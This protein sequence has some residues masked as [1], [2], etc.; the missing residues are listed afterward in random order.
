MEIAGL[1][2]LFA[3]AAATTAWATGR[4]VAALDGVDS[5][6]VAAEWFLEN[7]S[8]P[9]GVAVEWFSPRFASRPA[10]LRVYAP[11]FALTE[12]TLAFYCGGGFS[13]VI[14]NS[15]NRNVYFGPGTEHLQRERDWYARLERNADLLREI[16]GA[17]LELHVPTVW[18]YRLRCPIDGERGP[19]REQL[20]REARRS[21]HDRPGASGPKR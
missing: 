4:A 2:L 3:L 21:R 14:A 8:L 15:I 6:D 17:D 1:V 16:P 5:R 19:T 11:T 12:R 10:R 13:Y 9:A 7:V 20:Q 18:I